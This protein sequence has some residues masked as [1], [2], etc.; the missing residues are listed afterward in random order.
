MCSGS[1][2]STLTWNVTDNCINGE[3]IELEFTDT[4]DG[5]AWPGNGQVYDVMQGQS[6]QQALS[7]RTGSTVCVGG[8]QP[9]HNLVFGVGLDGSNPCPQNDCCVVCSD[10]MTTNTFT[11]P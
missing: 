9:N 11:C 1:Q 10:A 7:C 8:F 5:L 3:D 2:V 6:Y 4:V